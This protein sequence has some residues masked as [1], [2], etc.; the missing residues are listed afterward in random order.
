[1]WRLDVFLTFFPCVLKTGS[2]TDLELID[3][4][5]NS[6]NLPVSGLPALVLGACL[7]A[8]EWMSEIRT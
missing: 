6:R 4:L 7:R 3:W 2:L 1:M 5:V 8:L